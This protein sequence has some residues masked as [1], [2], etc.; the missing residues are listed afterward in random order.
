[1]TN[2]WEDTRLWN[3]RPASL[4][5]L[6]YRPRRY[7]RPVCD[8]CLL[9]VS[10]QSNTSSI[11]CV[12]TNLVKLGISRTPRGRSV[13]CKPI[14]TTALGQDSGLSGRVVVQVSDHHA[15][16]RSV[17]LENGPQIC[18]RAGRSGGHRRTL[19]GAVPLKGPEV[20]RARGA[21]D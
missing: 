7:W 6:Q 16:N 8:A 14:S 4:T 12:A 19:P 17:R 2:R 5:N 13:Y 15:Q 1:M 11:D 9:G 18:Q 10:D 21:G 3:S 20:R